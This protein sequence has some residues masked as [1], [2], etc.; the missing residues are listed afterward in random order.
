M[1]FSGLCR[2]GGNRLKG[3]TKT[4]KTTKVT[5]GAA[6]NAGRRVARGYDTYGTLAAWGRDVPKRPRRGHRGLARV[7]TAPVAVQ[8]AK[9]IPHV[10]KKAIAI[11]EGGAG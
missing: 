5:K 1:S 7:A 6:L 8:S 2:A 3:N 4:T 9:A 11:A 10:L